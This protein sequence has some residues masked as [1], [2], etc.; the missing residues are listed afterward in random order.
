MSEPNQEPEKPRRVSRRQILMTFGIALNAVAGILFRRARG[1]L[2]PR[3]GQAERDKKG[4]GVDNTRPVNTVPRGRNTAGALIAILSSAPGMATQAIFLAGCGGFLPISFR[5]LPS[6]ARIWAVLCGGFRNR[7][8]SC[9]PVT[10]ARIMPMAP[11]PRVRRR[12]A[13]L[14]TIS[15]LRAASFGSKPG[16]F[17]HSHRRQARHVRTNRRGAHAPDQRPRRVV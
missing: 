8:C 17:R 5:S 10:A 15:R 16:R 14:N 6:T 4:T 2:H 3:P 13:F 1:G 7:D 11:A 9:A 12:A